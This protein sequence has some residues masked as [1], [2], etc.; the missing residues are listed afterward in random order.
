VRTGRW[1]AWALCGLLAPAGQAAADGLGIGRGIDHVGSL[2]RLENFAAAGNV[3]TAQLGFS[4]TPV[5]TSPAGVENR[6][7]W[8]DNLGYLELDAFTADNAATAPYLAFLQDHEGAKFY[9]TQVVDA[10]RAVKFL[11]GAGYPNT[12]P[13]PAGPL[14]IQATGQVVGQTPLW[15]SIILTARVAPDNSNF[16]ID[17][18]QAEIR[19]LFASTPSLAPRPHA[20]TA[21]R[22]DTVWLVVQDL[23]AAI[24]FYR[25][26]DLEVSPGET[27]PYLGGRGARVVYPGG[28]V[29]DLLVPDGPGIVADFAADRGEGILGVSI[30]VLDLRLAHDLVQT[31]TGTTLPVFRYDGRNRFLVPASLVHGVLV[32][33]IEMVE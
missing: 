20:N 11:D 5:L 28:A 17:Y 9:G 14:T 7:I 1:V 3:W 25:G 32:E 18:D 21:Q 6:L 4:A 8:F 26:L 24:A 30:Q 2:V 10:A 13:I 27:V 23:D 19:D 16:F 31:N 15:E 33:M 22:I 29:L 12:G